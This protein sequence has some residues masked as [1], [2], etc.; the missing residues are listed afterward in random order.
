M[1]ARAITA[2]RASNRVRFEAGGF[3]FSCASSRD[4]ER[5]MQVAE[6]RVGPG[7]GPSLGMG[8]TDMDAKQP[9]KIRLARRFGV[10]PQRVFDAW[11]DSKTA[12]QWLFPPGATISL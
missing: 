11:T 7:F 2:R 1:L 5:T 4:G 3:N 12:G 8:I 9:V 10:P 6:S